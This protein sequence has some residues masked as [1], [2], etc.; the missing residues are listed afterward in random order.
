[1]EVKTV[2]SENFKD[3]LE[4]AKEVEPFFGPMAD[5][6]SFQS[7]LRIFIEQKQAFCIKRN[8]EFCGAI[9][10][11]KEENEILWFA[12]SQKHKGKGYGKLL[13]QHAIDE[14]VSSKEIKVQTFA[15]RIKVGEPA[16]NLYEKFGFVD[17][18][19]CENNPAGYPTVLMVKPP[20]KF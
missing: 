11:S 3:W 2:Q 7:A 6:A 13:L 10:I 12:V 4:L 1:M 18:K 16:R 5:E 17:F 14:L 8:G 9:A 19:Q 20:N 15:N